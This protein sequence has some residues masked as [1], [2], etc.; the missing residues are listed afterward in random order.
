MTK[1]SVVEFQPTTYITMKVV[2][3]NHVFIEIKKS[4]GNVSLILIKCPEQ[5]AA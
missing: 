4:K 3:I 1:Y 2:T 5:M